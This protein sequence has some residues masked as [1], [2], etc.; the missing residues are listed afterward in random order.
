VLGLASSFNYSTLVIS[1]NISFFPF[2]ELE[3]DKKGFGKRRDK[4]LQNEKDELLETN[5][6]C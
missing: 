6:Y 1:T 4:S 3:E 2:Y 5:H